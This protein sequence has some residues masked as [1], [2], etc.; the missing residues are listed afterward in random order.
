MQH[1]APEEAPVP[2]PEEAPV[3][4]PQEAP[5]PAPQEAPVQ[6]SPEQLVHARREP[7]GPCATGACWPMRDGSLVDHARREPAP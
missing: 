4:A 3:P 2:A 1:V 7:R 5:V 6:P